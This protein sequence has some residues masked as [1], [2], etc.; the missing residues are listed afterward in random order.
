MNFIPLS[1]QSMTKEEFMIA[2]VLARAAFKENLEGINAVRTAA[3]V[4]DAIQQLKVK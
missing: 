2:W 1:P 4:Y 3:D